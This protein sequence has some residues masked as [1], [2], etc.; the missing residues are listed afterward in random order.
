MNGKISGLLWG[1]AL[2][3]HGLPAC[4][5]ADSTAMTSKPA[6]VLPPSTPTTPPP[7]P[8]TPPPVVTMPAAPSSAAPATPTPAGTMTATPN[9]PPALPA[10]GSGPWNGSAGAMAPA[11]GSTAM[12]MAGA[13]EP[14]N[15]PPGSMQSGSSAAAETFC[16]KYEKH[17][18]FGKPMRHADRATCI[19]DFNA[20]PA[21][22]FCKT[23]HMDTAIA[24]TAAACNGM[25]S[26][27]CFSIH[28]LHATG[29]TD[30]TGVTYC[31]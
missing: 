22:Q 7:A 11:A 27:F 19:S 6:T 3:L 28:C 31:K 2:L 25:A 18:G 9:A 16:G 24:G 20:T 30:P 4:A 15:P 17:C 12:P 10:G 5:G 14:A 13:G 29:L 23:M 26:E 8:A 21:Q 1:S